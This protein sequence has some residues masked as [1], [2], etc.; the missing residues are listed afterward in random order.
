[1]K[2][3]LEPGALYLGDNGRCFCTD[4]AGM[5]ARYTGR[6]IS[7]QPVHRV[8][9]ADQRGARRMGV[10]LRCETCVADERRGR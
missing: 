9:N 3:V 7:G 1:M 2:T 10:T 6:D 8:T 4:R 5:S